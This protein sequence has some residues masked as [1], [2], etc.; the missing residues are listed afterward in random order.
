VKDSV[1][2]PPPPQQPPNPTPA[3]TATTTTTTS[4]SAAPAVSPVQ[5]KALRKTLYQRVVD[6]LKHYYNGFRLLG[7]DTTIAGRMV[8]RL[9]HGQLLTRRERRRVRG[10]KVMVNPVGPQN[11]RPFYISHL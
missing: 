5:E 6:E 11:Q 2:P 10:T 4:S 1:T 8:W 3:A 9:L 7:I